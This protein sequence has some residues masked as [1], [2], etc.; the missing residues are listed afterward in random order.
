MLFD[1]S[2]GIDYEIVLFEFVLVVVDD[3]FMFTENVPDAKIGGASGSLVEMHSFTY[4]FSQSVGLIF[5]GRRPELLFVSL[6]ENW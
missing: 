1:G 2:L 3:V 5:S 6:V 4:K